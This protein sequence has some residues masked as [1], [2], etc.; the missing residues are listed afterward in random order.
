MKPETWPRVRALF[1]EALGLEPAR[2]EEYLARECGGDAEVLREVRAMLAADADDGCATPLLEGE[3]GTLL[4]TDLTGATLGGFEV[5]RQIGA[6]G[7]GAVYEARQQRPQR[8]VALKALSTG[9]PSERARLRFEDEAEILARLR[10]PGIAQVLEAGTATVGHVE[11]PWFAM[12]LV[13]EPRTIDRWVRER[14]LDAAAVAELCG[15][16]CEAVHYAHQ[17]GVI[18]RDLKPANVLVDRHGQVKV[19]DFG[20]ARLTERDALT[21]YT[22][23]GEILGTLAYM[24]PER[25]ERGEGEDAIAADV[26]ALGVML[27]ELLAGRA[28]VALD[29]LPPARAMELL[30]AADPPPPSRARPGVPLELDWITMKAMARESGRRYASAAELAA[31]LARLRR[32]EP[33]VAGPPSAVYRLRKL[34]WRHRVLVGIATVAFVAVSI[35]LVVAIAGWR[36]VGAAER[37]ARRKAAVLAE[38]NRFQQDV[39]RGAYGTE[40]GRDVRLVDVID[41]A[42][43]AVELRRFSDPTIEVSVR[44]SVGSSFLGLGRLKEAEQQFVRARDLLERHGYDP[45]EDWS[46]TLRTNLATTYERLGKLDLAEPELRTALRDNVAAYGAGHVEVA[47]TQ[48]NLANLLI[49]RAAYGEALQLASDAQVS[50]ARRHGE[51]SEQSIN[52]RALIAQA[53]SFLGR[54]EEAVAAFAHARALAERHLPE[55]HP[56]R[57]AVLGG[58]TAFLFRRQRYAEHVPLAEELAKARE[59][60]DGANHPSTLSAWSALA[61]GCLGLGRHAEAEASLRRVA[62]GWQALGIRDGFDYVANQQNLTVAVRRQGRTDEA[63]ALA[64]ANRELAARSLPKGH[65]LFAVA[66]KEQGACLRELGRHADA[67]PLLLQAHELLERVVGPKDHRTQKVVTEL[68]DLYRAWDRP[69]DAERWQARAGPAK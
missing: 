18:H 62:A 45:H 61:A 29:D 66:T 40:K 2:R 55:D 69:Q 50:F 21:R 46:I 14:N 13:E 6:G 58:C 8:T 19:I 26:Y 31:D 11:V 36:R 7:M 4:A 24:S 63:E 59:R 54:D 10:H 34:A 67:E 53:L 35:G 64:R 9:F 39:L 15:R 17:R 42:A 41:K 68:V 38:V 37:L 48:S 57:L 23:T 60:V 65:W 16:V 43:A 49:K 3:P 25:L 32:H 28:P 27:Y 30:R 12:E 20:I 44:N 56:A 47:L 51:H 1:E 52:A 22:R 5:L 33:L